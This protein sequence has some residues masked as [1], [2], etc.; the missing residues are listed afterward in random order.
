AIVGH[1]VHGFTHFTVGSSWIQIGFY[2]A[3]G[4]GIGQ[5][6]TSIGARSSGE[7]HVEAG[8]IAWGLG[9]L[10]VAFITVPWIAAHPLVATLLSTAAAVDVGARWAIGGATALDGA[11][12]AAFAF[13]VVSTFVLLVPIPEARDLAARVLVSGAGPFAVA[14]F[15]QR[16]ALVLRRGQRR[17]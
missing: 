4:L 14:H 1:L 9:T 17:G 5:R 6:L 15:G 16:L 11:L 2:V 12:A 8:T 7:W 13:I 10:G 3:L